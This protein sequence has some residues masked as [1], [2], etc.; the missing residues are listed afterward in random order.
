ELKK[1]GIHDFVILEQATDIGGTW[2]DNSYPGIAVDVPSFTYQYSFE[3]HDWSRVFA[4]GVEVKAYADH[5]LE[6]YGL[7]AHLRLNTKV[8]DATFDEDQHVWRLQT[9]DRVITARFMIT[10]FGVL[11]QPKPPDIPG[12]EKF[13]RKTMHTA[14]WDHSHD[15]AG[16]RVAVIG[17]GATAV[18]LVPKLARQA[19]QLYV[20]Q[21]TPIWILPKADFRIP[22]VVRRV[23]RRVPFAQQSVRLAAAAAIEAG[24]VLGVVYNRQL[25]AVTRAVERT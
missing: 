9:E 8:T 3:L 23:F 24:M 6:K 10:A 22:E 20:Y 2:R 19:E 14:R 13:A 25:P 5:C 7:R 17:T 12:V 11:T 18:Q 15:V 4:K 21:R 1:A 16:E